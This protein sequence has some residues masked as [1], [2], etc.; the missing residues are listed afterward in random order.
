VTRAASLARPLAALG[1]LLF[2]AGCAVSV[3]GELDESRANRT[4]ALLGEHGIAAEKT[5]DP[6]EPTHF[7]VEVASDDASRAV[8]LLVDEGPA[9]H[10]APGV[11]DALG[12]GSLVPS[13]E[14]EHERMLAG[15][16]GDLTRSLEGVDGVLS[17]RVHVAATRA[18]PLDV[19]EAA[20]PTAAVLIRHRGA[21]P[22]IREDDVRKLV[23]YAVPGLTP[24]HVAVV[25]STAAPA[26]HA[27]ELVRV[28]PI[29]ATRATAR[30]IRSVVLLVLVVNVALAAGLVLL[31]SRLRR[32][33]ASEPPPPRPDVLR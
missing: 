13:P 25:Y 19:G 33:R 5:A 7:R 24:D 12:T 22:P 10:D 6:S 2:A 17:A 32:F 16:A 4:V 31:W 11:L 27:P 9:S 1:A 28:G 15:V 18:D 21:T 29:S 14:S 20:P 26:R 23:A 8:A 30:S 3:Q